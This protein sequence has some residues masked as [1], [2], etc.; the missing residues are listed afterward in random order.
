MSFGADPGVDGRRADGTRP[1]IDL[2]FEEVARLA[3]QELTPGD[4]YRE[5]LKR[6]LAGLAAPAGAVWGKAAHGDCHLQYQV[7]LPQ[8]GFDHSEDD[9]RSHAQLLDLAFEHARPCLLPPHSSA[10]ISRQGSPDPG[11]PTDF[12][13]LVAPVQVDQ[14]V[15]ALV[16][17]WQSPDC[18]P[19]AL[20]GSMQFLMRMADLAS[21]YLRNRQR[22]QMIAQQQVWE[23]LEAFALRT[24]GSLNPTELA[25]LVANDGR[26]LVECDC[27]SVAMRYGRRTV[28]EAISGVDVIEKRSKRV[29]LM[30]TLCQRVLASGERVV[31]RGV[32]D[33]SLPPAVLQALDGYLGESAAKL[34]VV[35]PLADQRDRDRGRPARSVLLIECF[36]APDA[37]EQLI[38]RLEVVGRY[39]TGPLYN[40]AEYRRI[41]LRWLWQPLAW[42][43]E[44]LGSKARAVA[45]LAAFAGVALTAMLTVVPYPLKLD[46]K[47]QLLP[48][49]RRWIYAPVEGHVAHFAQGVAPGSP[50]AKDQSLVL[51]YDVQLELK[52]DQ[53]ASEIQGAQQEI[54]AL[55][56]QMTTAAT[57]AE[58][59]RIGAER[60]RQEFVRDRTR[61]ELRKW[62]ERTHADTQPGYFWLTSPLDGTVLNWDFRENLTNRYVKPSDPLLRIGDKSRRWEVELKIPQEHIGQV[63]RAFD[64]GDPRA[65]LD[66]DLL[67]LSAPTHTFKG[68]LARDRIAGEASVNREDATAYEPVVLAAVRIDGPGIAPGE[69]VPRELLVSGT[70]VHSK[71][72][73]GR[74][75]M[76]YALFYGVWEFV[77]DKVVFF[78]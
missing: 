45:A 33:D 77:Y 48:E 67:V 56:G 35:L 31:F 21:L 75:A 26:R 18:D 68:K 38:N 1:Y 36:E 70:E 47:G 60:K 52:L 17:V 20:T 34:V 15:T 61:E 4:Y 14:E 12:F 9:R 8:V 23:Q 25:C 43:R 3:D 46:A 27:L 50:V 53:L 76:G 39:A 41:P 62:R 10:G 2:L 71:I 74:R 32:Q 44:G 58:R 63:L 22:R 51:M 5:F 59:R 49:E 11:N 55:A 54:T 72:R 19:G 16:E 78:F 73:C 13:A 7:N 6:V 28:I 37:P 65:E 30:R 40:A 42:F 57:A 69:R 29:R 24:Q 66:V 64:Q